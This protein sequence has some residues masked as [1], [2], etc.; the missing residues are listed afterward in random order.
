MTLVGHLGGL[1][2][3]LVLGFLVLRSGL[4]VWAL[5]LGVSSFFAAAGLA[6]GLFDS[7]IL[8]ALPARSIGLLEND[9]LQAMPLYVFM[10]VLLQ[11]L[12]L[13]D[14]LYACLLRL[15][16]PF[17]GAPVL[18]AFGLGALLAPTNGSVAASSALLSRLIAPRLAH[19][20]A[21][22]SVS[23]MSVAATIGVVVPPSLVLL[24]LGDAMLS[25]HLEASRL[26]GYLQTSQTIINTRDVMH[27]AL[28]PALGVLLLWASIACL[29]SR[30]LKPQTKVK[31]SNRQCI[32]GLITASSIVLLLAGVFTGRLYAVEAAATGA[33]LMLLFSFAT[34]ALNFAAWREVCTQALSLSGALFAL[35]VGA[36]TFS[37]V[38]RLFGTDR[39]LSSWLLASTFTPLMGAA[40][41]LILV[42][43]CAW[44]LD[45]FEMIFVIIP[46]VA[47]VLIVHLG[48]AQQAA[49][50]LLL[51]L[52]L[53]FLVPPMGYAVMM[54]RA[55][56]PAL[57]TRQLLTE[58]WPMLLAQIVITAA[59]FAFPQTVHWL[60][61]A[62]TASSQEPMTDA[63][64]ERQMSEMSAPSPSAQ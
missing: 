53:S 35:L 40:I 50:L 29:K 30:R 21:A 23:V 52:Q 39:L 6:A 10:G 47:P 42:G 41:V 44:V 38:F 54:A 36:T 31:I 48:D 51:M 49:V 59:V 12:T 2:M 62:P 13:A 22:Q 32:T 8:Q 17:A 4:P 60:D 18:A 43:L 37:L 61:A 11:R 5:L 55:S 27:A 28:L 15:L 33:V 14:A 20:G 63:E 24:L 57:T 3:L 26:P 16:S 58:L 19:L 45:A 25:A 56:F 9:L 34:R 7:R 64:V 1:W 46:L